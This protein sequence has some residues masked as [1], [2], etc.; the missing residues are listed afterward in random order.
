MD[1]LPIEVILMSKKQ[2][3]E[4]E[5]QSRKDNTEDAMNAYNGFKSGMSAGVNGAGDSYRRNNK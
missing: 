2:S 3:I 5:M 4:A 1:N